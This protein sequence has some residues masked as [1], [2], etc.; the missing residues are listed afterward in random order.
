M[1]RLPRRRAGALSRRAGGRGVTARRR[2]ELAERALR[3]SPT[4]RPWPP[5]CTSA[6]C[7]SR[8]A[9][10]RPTQA[11]EVDDA[12]GR[13]PVRARRPHGLGATPTRRRRRAARRRRARRRRR[14]GRGRAAGAPGDYPG[15]PGAARPRRAHDGF[16]AGH[17]ALD[18]APAARRCAP[19]FEAARRARPRG[20]RHVD[21]RRGRDRHRL[22]DRRAARRDAV[23]DAYM[24]VVARRDGRARSG[25]AAGAGR[26][27]PRWTPRRAGR[28]ARR[29]KVGAA[30]SRL[31]LAARRVPGRARAPTRSAELLELLGA[32]A[33]NG[34][35][36]AEGRGAL[37]AGS[38]SAW[39]RRASTSPTRPRFARTL[40]RAFDAEGVAEGAA[41]A[42]PG[43]RRPPR[44][45]RHALGR[46]RRR[47]RDA[48]PATRSAPGG[49]A[50]RPRAHQPGARRRRRGRRGRARGADRARPLRD[51]PLVRQ[52]RAPQGDAADRH[53]ARRDVP[54]RGR[55]HRP[56][57]SRDVRFTDSVLRLLERH[58]GAD[59]DARAWSA[60]AEFY[61]RRFA[62]AWCARRCARRASG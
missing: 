29:A 55:P 34:L 45:P 12:H 3:A 61:G 53:D 17:R 18:P 8:F 38:A 59:R 22:V 5:S 2:L 40:P 7:C 16:D 57:A 10:S 48:R 52:R 36:H 42:H 23:T 6:R 24:K 62:T 31:D 60:E 35:A 39:R 20:V 4:A 54:D 25:C 44:R 37:S 26:S 13:G 14:A 11:T 41:P 56:A 33:F 28:R 58:R 30:T 19:R 47:R 51:A 49:G 46:A 43:R 27:A 21:R 9:R 50:V 1:A 32:L 15:L